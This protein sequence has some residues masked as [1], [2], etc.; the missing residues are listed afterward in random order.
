MTTTTAAPTG[1]A[2]YTRETPLLNRELA[3]WFAAEGF[4]LKRFSPPIGE[5]NCGSSVIAIFRGRQE[6]A[7]MR[8]DR[9][10]AWLKGYCYAKL[11]AANWAAGLGS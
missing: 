9:V 5:K 8:P 7:R 1:F 4:G 3:L 11:E 10:N 2:R 6:L